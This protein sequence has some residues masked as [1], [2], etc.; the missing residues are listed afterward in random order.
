MIFNRWLLELQIRRRSSVEY[1]TADFTL[2]AATQQAVPAYLASSDT[3]VNSCT[4]R[5][6][7]FESI[8]H[9]KPS[10][11][12]QAGQLPLIFWYSLQKMDIY[13]YTL[14]TPT[15][16]QTDVIHFIMISFDSRHILEHTR[17]IHAPPS[18]FSFLLRWCRFSSHF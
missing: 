10:I 5:K 2:T 14:H 9:Y 18:F 1:A 3:H 13:S 16:L 8:P 15:H 6:Q 17:Y 4:F 12:R 7:A 11:R